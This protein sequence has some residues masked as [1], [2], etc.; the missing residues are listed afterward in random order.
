MGMVGASYLYGTSK[1]SKTQVQN[2]EEKFLIG[3]G[4]MKI[5][6]RALKYQTSME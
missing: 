5:L 2:L 1:P 4:Q 6:L 3:D